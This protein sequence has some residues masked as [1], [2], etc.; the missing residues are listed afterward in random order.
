MEVILVK[1][2]RKLG[3]I[4]DI[5]KV[6]N[7][8]ARNYLIPQ[9][10]A[11]RA[12]E[13]NKQY[14]VDQKHKLEEQET[15][16]KSKVGVV[17]NIIQDKELLFIRQSAEDGRLFGSVS[18]KEIAESLSKASDQSISYL[19]IALEKPIKSLGVFNVE[20]RL[21]A[22]VSVNVVVIVARSESE[23]QEYSAHHKLQQGESVTS[24]DEITV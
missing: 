6:K 5:L 1:P 24:S 12:T 11:I 15:E 14:I 18:N 8:F 7:G 17:G 21:H 3:K 9:K 13:L 16:V 2:V 20:V 4:A 22:E 10:L 19:T 23:A